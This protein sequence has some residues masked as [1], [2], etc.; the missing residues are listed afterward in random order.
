[1]LGVK[2]YRTSS[3]SY[4][5]IRAPMRKVPPTFGSSA[6]PNER[7]ITAH[8]K[9]GRTKRTTGKGILLLIVLPPF[10]HFQM[11]L[12]PI[13]LHLLNE[14]LIMKG[15]TILMAP[16]PFRGQSVTQQPQN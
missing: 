1:M 5:G 7:G 2:G 8:K 11:M 10:C 12:Y 4:W 14:P 6:N 3:R 13:W 15:V 9:T 16:F